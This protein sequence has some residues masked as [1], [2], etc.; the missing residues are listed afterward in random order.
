V[1]FS[2]VTD[3]NMAKLLNLWNA[4]NIVYSIGLHSV[5]VMAS[6]PHF[7]QSYGHTIHMRSNAE[8]LEV[9]HR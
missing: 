2:C 9:T 7:I 1:A 4:E 6:Q 5:N 3:E 8:L